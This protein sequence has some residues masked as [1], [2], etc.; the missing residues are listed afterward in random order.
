LTPDQL[1]LLGDAIETACARQRRMLD[2]ALEES[3]P[4]LPRWIVLRLLRAGG[5]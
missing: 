4:A 3:I 2:D 5:P 1:R